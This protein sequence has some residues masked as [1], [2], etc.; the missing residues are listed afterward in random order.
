M[1][2]I[3][4]IGLIESGD[5]AGM[6]VKILDDSKSTGGYLILTGENLDNKDLE[7]FDDWVA[8]K[9]E[10]EGYFNESKWE[11]KWL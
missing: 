2:E 1:I 3:G 10:L 5:Q 7:A 8:T 6:Q 11:I 9:N 4:I